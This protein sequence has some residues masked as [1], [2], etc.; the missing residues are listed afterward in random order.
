MTEGK[1]MVAENFTPTRWERVKEAFTIWFEKKFTPPSE[2]TPF[3]PIPEIEEF[4]LKY[5]REYCHLGGDI[6]RVISSID[7]NTELNPLEKVAN[8]ISLFKFVVVK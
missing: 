5:Y 3:V 8:F 4:R 6:G 1:G 2:E 7:N